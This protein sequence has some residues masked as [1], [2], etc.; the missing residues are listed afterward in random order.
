MLWDSI[1]LYIR[2]DKQKLHFVED[3]RCE[4]HFDQ[5]SRAFQLNVELK[6]D[7]LIDAAL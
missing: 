3:D 7:V 1:S 5:Q 2:N 6:R 4:F